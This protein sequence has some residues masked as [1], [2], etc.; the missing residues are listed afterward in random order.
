M[1][2]CAAVPPDYGPSIGQLGAIT[3]ELDADQARISLSLEE[4]ARKITRIEAALSQID[5]RL[6]SAG[7]KQTTSEGSIT[8][9]RGTLSGTQSRVAD[10]DARLVG[11]RRIVM[12]ELCLEEVN[13][14]VRRIRGGCDG[15][16]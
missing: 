9:L 4:M 1:A 6:I 8:G 3:R 15:R 11:L 10:L 12:G 16:H 5:A 14:I 2:G 7:Q 13:N